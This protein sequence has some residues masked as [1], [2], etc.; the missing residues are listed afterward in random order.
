MHSVAVVLDSGLLHYIELLLAKVQFWNILLLY[1]VW[2]QSCRMSQHWESV[3]SSGSLVAFKY[4]CP[5]LYVVW[6]SI[7]LKATSEVVHNQVRDCLSAVQ[8]QWQQQWCHEVQDI[9]EKGTS[10]P[11]IQNQIGYDEKEG[12]L[13][14]FCSALLAEH[15]ALASADVSCSFFRFRYPKAAIL[16]SYSTVVP[17]KVP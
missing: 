6:M 11:T 13:F 10:R 2:Y 12:W 8:L 17:H 14:A 5:T 3:A 9:K 16:S 1:Q 7:P 15:S 4:G